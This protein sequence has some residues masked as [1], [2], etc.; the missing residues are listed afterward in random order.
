MPW[1]MASAYRHTHKAKGPAAKK[2]WSAVANKVLKESGD[3]AKAIKIANAA[4]AKRKKK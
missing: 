3:D 2:Q 4:I 1:T